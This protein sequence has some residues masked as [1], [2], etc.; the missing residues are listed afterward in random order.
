MLKRK[1]E[2]QCIV[3][4]MHKHIHP[5]IERKILFIRFL[6]D[7]YWFITKSFI[8]FFLCFFRRVLW[9]HVQKSYYFAKIVQDDFLY[10]NYCSNVFFSFLYRLHVNCTLVDFMIFFSLTHIYVRLNQLFLL[11]ES[12]CSSHY[13]LYWA[14]ASN[15]IKTGWEF[16]IIISTK[17]KQTVENINRLKLSKTKLI[18]SLNKKLNHD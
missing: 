14:M 3:N 4:S 17:D 1:E 16:K 18:W 15:K 13:S 6:F 9:A 2:K 8:T 11:L 12:V 7:F 10:Y 5:P